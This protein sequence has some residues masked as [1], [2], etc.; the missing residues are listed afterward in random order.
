MSDE[1]KKVEKYL[2]QLKQN[3]QNLKPTLRLMGNSILNSSTESFENQ[4]SPF[5][6][7]WKADRKSVV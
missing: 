4:K 6:E 7:K 5:G 2:E 1:F 3:M